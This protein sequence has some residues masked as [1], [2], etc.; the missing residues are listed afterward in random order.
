[1]IL[2]LGFSLAVFCHPCSFRVSNITHTYLSGSTVLDLLKISPLLGC[3]S[4]SLSI[5]AAEA[6]GLF[7]LFKFF[8]AS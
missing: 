3:F 5:E 7:S 8:S 4:A 6:A 2:F 1:M